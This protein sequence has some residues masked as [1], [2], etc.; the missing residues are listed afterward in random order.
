[1]FVKTQTSRAM[2][3]PLVQDLL[4]Y[5]SLHVLPDAVKEKIAEEAPGVVEHT[6]YLQTTGIHTSDPGPGW[7]VCIGFHEKRRRYYVEDEHSTIPILIRSLNEEGTFDAGPDEPQHFFAIQNTTYAVSAEYDNPT[8]VYVRKIFMDNRI[9]MQHVKR[10]CDKIC[11]RVLFH[12]RALRFRDI[13]VTRME[14][15]A[16][17]S[18]YKI[19]YKADA[20]LSNLYFA[21]KDY[22]RLNRP[23]QQV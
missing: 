22:H 9:N 13:V 10:L 20:R 16:L 11:E 12:M 8:S 15:N 23:D 4:K 2:Q 14:S 19:R 1:M 7:V 21:S 5:R 6:T 3:H 18:I 17:G